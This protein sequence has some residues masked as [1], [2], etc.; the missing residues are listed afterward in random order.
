MLHFPDLPPSEQPPLQISD[1]LTTVAFRGPE[2]IIHPNSEGVANLVFDV[3]KGARGVKGGTREADE[4][5]IKS[6]DP[7]FEVR[8]IVAVKITMGIGRYVSAF[9]H[10]TRV[11]SECH[12]LAR[13]LY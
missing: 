10:F 1:T 4:G 13:T 8:C 5:D 6:T 11:I 12:T 3:P 2:Y 7:L 9:S